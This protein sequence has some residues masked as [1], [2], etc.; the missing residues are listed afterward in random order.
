LT[1]GDTWGGSFYLRSAEPWW[2]RYARG[3]VPAEVRDFG[4]VEFDGEVIRPARSDSDAAFVA[5][6]ASRVGVMGATV[7]GTQHFRGRLEFEGH[8][9]GGY[10]IDD[11]DCAGAVT[12][13][14]GLSYTYAPNDSFDDEEMM[15]VP[16]AQNEPRDLRTT[17]NRGATGGHESGIYLIDLDVA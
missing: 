10:E 16:V 2:S 12:R 9:G 17:F 5:L 4:V 3:P 13:V 14:R 8:G 6:G 15:H 1:I 11:L 7:H